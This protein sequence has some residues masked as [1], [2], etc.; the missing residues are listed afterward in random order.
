MTMKEP[1]GRFAY[2][3]SQRRG[4]ADQLSTLGRSG[5][6]LAGLAV[7]S[8]K[9]LLPVFRWSHSVDSLEVTGKMAVVV[10]AYSIHHLLNTQVCCLQQNPCLLHPYV[11]QV[12]NQCL[13]DVLFEQVSQARR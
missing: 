8:L 10:Y 12:L 7:A 1:E 4:L 9:T 13:A 3:H 2:D 5:Y 11:N 6:F